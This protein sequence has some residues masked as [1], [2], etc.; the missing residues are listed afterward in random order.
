MPL[1]QYVRSDHLGGGPRRCCTHSPVQLGLCAHGT[2][3]SSIRSQNHVSGQSNHYFLLMRLGAWIG[4][5]L[6]RHWRVT[7]CQPNCSSRSFATIHVVT[8]M[9]YV[10]MQ[11]L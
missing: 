6:K 1:R 10:S 3:S 5:P 7:N 2:K 11:R 4:A 9:S 8:S